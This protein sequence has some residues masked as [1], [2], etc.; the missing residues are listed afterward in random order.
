MIEVLINAV[1]IR[2]WYRYR[3]N[4]LFTVMRKLFR[5]VMIRYDAWSIAF[6]TSYKHEDLGQL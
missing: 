5:L 2:R 6:A 4:W 1:V 3:R